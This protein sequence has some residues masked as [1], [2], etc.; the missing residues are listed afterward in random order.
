MGMFI[1]EAW[2]ADGSAYRMKTLYALVCYFKQFYDT[3]SIHDV[4]PLV[5]TYYSRS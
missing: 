3:N 2:K 5:P 1:L 4:N